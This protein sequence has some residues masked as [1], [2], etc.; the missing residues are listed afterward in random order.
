MREAFLAHACE[1]G[2]DDEWRR[3]VREVWAEFEALP[4]PDEIVIRHAR[5]HAHPFWRVPEQA[6]H[7]SGRLAIRSRAKLLVRKPAPSPTA[8][9]KK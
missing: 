7:R 3:E 5:K 4:E 2:A 6:K 8:K 9:Q 1:H